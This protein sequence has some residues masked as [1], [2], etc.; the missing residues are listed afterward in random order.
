MAIIC[1]PVIRRYNPRLHQRR[2]NR[3]RG[4]RP[5]RNGTEYIAWLY[6]D[7]IVGKIRVRWRLSNRSSAIA[8]RAPCRLRQLPLLIQLLNPDFASRWTNCPEIFQSAPEP[9][10]NTL[11]VNFWV[12]SAATTARQRGIG[13]QIPACTLFLALVNSS[14]RRPSLRHRRKARRAVGN[15]FHSVFGDQRVKIPNDTRV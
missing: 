3:I 13:R 4:H 2:L 8:R 7:C 1:C 12:S 6:L 5:H 11:P 14:W 9:A 10:T 15:Q